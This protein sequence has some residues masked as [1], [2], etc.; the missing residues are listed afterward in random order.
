MDTIGRVVKTENNHATVALVRLSSCGSSCAS[1]GLCKQEELYIDAKNNIGA[2][3]GSVVE[4]SFEDKI[5]LGLAFMIYILPIILA[6]AVYFLFDYIFGLIGGIIGV[7][8]AI[9]I[10]IFII[11]KVNKKVSGENK[12]NGV[13]ERIIS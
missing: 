8:L 12:Y 6:F 10:W 4:I 13:I 9:A 2:E 1:C 5:P 11:M 3:V 7:V